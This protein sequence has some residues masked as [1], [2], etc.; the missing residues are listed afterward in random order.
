M[1]AANLKELCK[2]V[3]SPSHEV[4]FSAVKSFPTFQSAALNP[5]NLFASHRGSNLLG[6][7]ADL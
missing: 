4:S 2:L 1:K 7:A 6:K 5:I 3:T